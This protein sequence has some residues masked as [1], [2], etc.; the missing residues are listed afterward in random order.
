LPDERRCE[1]PTTWG[2]VG[3]ALVFVC[4][5]RLGLLVAGVQSAVRGGRV[6]CA[7]LCTVRLLCT[8]SPAMN[9]DVRLWLAG[10]RR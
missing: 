8:G 5:Q 9:M 6:Q 2:A 7:Q 3:S 4:G 1:G 10:G